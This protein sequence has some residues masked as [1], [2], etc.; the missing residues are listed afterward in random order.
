M[1]GEDRDVLLRELDEAEKELRVRNERLQEL[2]VQSNQFQQLEHGI[3]IS[4]DVVDMQFR[5]HYKKK[6]R[7]MIDKLQKDI[8]E[9]EEDVQRALSRVR[10]IRDELKLG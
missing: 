2:Y 1:N 10:D 3:Q 8:L 9:C 7:V 4:M 5:E 6:N